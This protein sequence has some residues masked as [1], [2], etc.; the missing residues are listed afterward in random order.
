MSYFD[1]NPYVWG[2]KSSDIG[3]SVV[4]MVV[5][6]E[7]TG[8]TINLNTSMQMTFTNKVSV[9]SQ[10]VNLTAALNPDTGMTYH[11]IDV[12]STGISVVLQLSPP[13]GATSFDV[14]FQIEVYPTQDSHI[15]KTEVN[16]TDPSNGLTIVIPQEIVKETGIYYVALKPMIEGEV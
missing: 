13:E 4:N 9:T 5:K 12:T 6:D 3:S 1:D 2:T 11:K 14:F 16:S 10:E 8:A 15:F 7:E